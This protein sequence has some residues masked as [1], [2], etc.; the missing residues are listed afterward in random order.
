MKRTE[1]LSQMNQSAALVARAGRTLAAV[2]LLLVW[3]ITW[4]ATPA[5]A[6][7]DDYNKAFLANSDFAGR[8]FVAASFNHANLKGSNLQGADLT[9]ASFFAANLEDVD[10]TGANM[11]NSTLDTARLSRANFTNAVLEGAFASNAKFEGA[12]VTGADFTD[13]QL[14]SDILKTLCKTA[15]GTNPVTGRETRETLNCD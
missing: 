12:I 9:R 2:L 10:L 5:L 6:L 14:R 8:S 4:A 7:E 13:V 3:A 11:T 1:I 15:S